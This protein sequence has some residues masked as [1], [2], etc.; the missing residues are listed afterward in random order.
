MPEN[1]RHARLGRSGSGS[2]VVGGSVGAAVGGSGIVGGIGV[3]TNG[4]NTSFNKA[5]IGF[6]QIQLWLDQTHCC[7]DVKIVGC[8]YL[9]NR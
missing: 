4:S 9:R 2:G 3:A 8:E 5:S 1:L 7:L 6:I